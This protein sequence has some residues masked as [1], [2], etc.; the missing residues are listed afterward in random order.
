MSESIIKLLLLSSYIANYPI[1]RSLGYSLNKPVA[2]ICEKM[3][4]LTKLAN[5]LSFAPIILDSSEGNPKVKK[6][7]VGGNSQGIFLRVS[8]SILKTTKG[9]SLIEFLCNLSAS[10]TLNGLPCNVIPVFVCENGL[11]IR[12]KDDVFEVFYQA[13]KFYSDR[14]HPIVPK[15]HELPVVFDHI[16]RFSTKKTL[17]PMEAAVF[18][19][20]NFAQENG[21]PL[22]LLLKIAL[23]MQNQ[24][25]NA[26]S[27]DCIPDLFIDTLY[28]WQERTNFNKI[29]TLPNLSMNEENDFDRSMFVKSSKGF[30][31]MS[32]KM[33]SKIIQPLTASYSTSTIKEA[34]Y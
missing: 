33:F 28:Q 15:A 5:T 6:M 11:P 22:K 19:L 7:L 16:K 34:L 30:L 1:L 2:L 3:N 9:I 17:S 18:F 26:K 24:D 25:E 23:Q 20:Y 13:N 21:I 14:L 4:D 8:E 31:Y 10:G 32:D 29:I 27:T 12:L